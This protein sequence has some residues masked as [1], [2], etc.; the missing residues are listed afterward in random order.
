MPEKN[1]ETEDLG[2]GTEKG[3]LLSL[4]WLGKVYIVLEKS[5]GQSGVWYHIVRVHDLFE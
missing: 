3:K 2:A 5:G 1:K 4:A